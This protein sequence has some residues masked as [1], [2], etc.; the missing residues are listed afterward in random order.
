MLTDAA[1]VPVAVL[2]TRA[3]DNDAPQL[4][5]L[6]V[7]HRPIAGRRGRPRW[8]FERLE[9]DASYLSRAN[10]RL[11]VSHRIVDEIAHARR[12]AGCGLGKTRWVVERTIAWL[13][14][15]RRL[16]VRY[17]R[18]AEVHEAFMSLACALICKRILN[19]SS[20]PFS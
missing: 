4:P 10:H 6:L 2:L 11:L 16:R 7:A 8:R 14:Q 9:A 3:N 5:A 18:L 1:G 15:F 19:R 17:E 20:A 12:R 13:H